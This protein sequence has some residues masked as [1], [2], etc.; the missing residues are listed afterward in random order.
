MFDLILNDFKLLAF[1][2]LFN[3]YFA[4]ASIPVGFFLAVIFALMRQS[5]HR[6]IM[7]FSKLYIYA[8]RGSPLFIQFFMIYSIMLALNVPYFKPWGV[9][10]ILLHPLFLGPFI[11]TLNTIAYSAEIFY[12]ALQAIPKS[13]IEAARAFGFSKKEMFFTVT[14]PNMLRLAWPA[15]T[16]EVVFLFHSTALV[17]YTLPV[18]NEQKDLMNKAGELFEK[19]YNAFLHYSVAGAYFLLISL[20]IF[21]VAGRIYK[22]MCAHLKKDDTPSFKFRPQYLR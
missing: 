21:F 7:W 6:G 15:Y 22:R 17:Y 8:F 3:I 4:V 5:Q 10:E 1:P 9:S 12:G 2:S 13:E 19:D 20:V 18:I 16:N 14:W 11:L